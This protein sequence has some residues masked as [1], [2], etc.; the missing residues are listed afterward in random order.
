MLNAL[1]KAIVPAPRMAGVMPGSASNAA[2]SPPT[3]AVTNATTSVGGR[4]ASTAAL[5]DL[6][7]SRVQ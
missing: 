2:M 1:R 7:V 6:R 5:L 4:P 3:R